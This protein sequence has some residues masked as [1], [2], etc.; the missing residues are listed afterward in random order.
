MTHTP[1]GPPATQP[2]WAIALKVATTVSLVLIGAAAAAVAGFIGVV[3]YTGCF[4]SCSGGNQAGGL[5]LY[6]LALAF[7]VSGPV[8]ARIMWRRAR[9]PAAMAVWGALGLGVPLAY[10]LS[11]GVIGTLL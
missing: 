7:L 1:Y 3:T 2:G 5:V 8:L 6:A 11:S 9:T 10:L 4:I